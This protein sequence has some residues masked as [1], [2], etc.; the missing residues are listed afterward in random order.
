MTK[1]KKTVE[2]ND[3]M[4]PDIYKKNR[5]Q[6]RKDLIEFKKNRRLSNLLS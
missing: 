1:E 3:L 2:K 4:A 5:G 6:I